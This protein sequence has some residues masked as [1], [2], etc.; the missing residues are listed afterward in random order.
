MKRERDEEE[1][2]RGKLKVVVEGRGRMKERIG[3]VGFLIPSL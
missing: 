1:R 3:R 2:R